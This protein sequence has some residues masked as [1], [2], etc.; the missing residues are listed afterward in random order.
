MPADPVDLTLD[1][2]RAVTAYAAACARPALVLTGDE[3]PRRA[4]ETAQAFADGG[5]RTKAVRDAAWAA[6]RAARDAVDAAAR[7]AA[8]A[9]GHAAGAAFLHPFAKDTQVG[10]ILGAA[11]HAARAFELSGQDAGHHL[12]R[13]RDLA[14]PTVVAVLRRYP[15]AP[16]GYGRAGQLMRSLDA[17]LRA[18]RAAR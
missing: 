18:G 17:M 6:H 8:R 13:C 2:I 11:A 3:R 12:A 16:A 5:A 7:E 10:H 15:P 9:A 4:I 14:T 1:E